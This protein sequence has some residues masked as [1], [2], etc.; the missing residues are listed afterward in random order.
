MLTALT[1]NRLE[2]P[3]DEFNVVMKVDAPALTT[4][5]LCTALFLRGVLWTGL[6][7]M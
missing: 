3:V 7:L 5:L 2:L 4:V 6:I 1:A